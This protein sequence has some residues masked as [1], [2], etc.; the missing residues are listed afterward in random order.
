MVSTTS[1]QMYH[2]SYTYTHIHSFN[3]ICLSNNPLGSSA[4]AQ[5]LRSKYGSSR[6]SSLSSSDLGNKSAITKSKSS[7]AVCP[8]PVSDSSDDDRTSNFTRRINREIDSDKKSQPG[9]S[10]PRNLYLQKKRLAFKIGVRGTEQGCFTWPRGIA[11]SPD[12][13]I[14]VAD[15]SNHRVQVFDS[16]GRF[17]FE[18]GNYGSNEGEFD[19]L[20]GVAVNRIGQF[21]VSDRYNH[22]I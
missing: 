2:T 7:H 22:R 14:V 21:I 1:I 15:S 10:L 20:A 18:F 13:N 16:T 4:W 11:V 5:Y 19:C 9:Y 6:G 8:T 3:H 17:L 12:N